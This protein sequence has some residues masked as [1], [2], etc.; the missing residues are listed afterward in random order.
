ME[1]AV[2]ISSYPVGVTRLLGWCVN[3]L[4]ESHVPP[5][6]PSLAGDYGIGGPPGAWLRLRGQS[7]ARQEEAAGGFLRVGRPGSCW[8]GSQPEKE[9]P[10][11][12]FFFFFLIYFWLHWVF[13]AVGGLSLVAASRATLRCGVWTYHCGGFSCCGAEALS[14]WASVVVARG[15]SCSTA[16]GTFRNQGSNPCPLHRQADS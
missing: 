5:W 3:S 4:G 15:L 2:I 6:I 16:C 10:S 1:A 12:A 9:F 13:V 11:H 7:W 14:A 8:A